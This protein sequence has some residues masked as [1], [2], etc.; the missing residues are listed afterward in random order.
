MDILINT[1]LLIAFFAGMASL[2]AP[3]CISVLL[4]TYFASIF[5][6]K[7]QVFFMTFVYF[8][9]I[10]LVFL[11]LGLGFGSL[12]VLFTQFH[13]WIYMGGA[14]FLLILAFSIF[15]GFHFML[16]LH[17][18]PKLKNQNIPSIFILGL[19]SGLATTCCAP[20]LAGVLT[21]SVL[22]GS[23]LLG[24]IYALTY[25]LGMVIPL[26]I[27]AL[28]LDKINFTQKFLIF[29][30]TLSYKILGRKVILTMSNF[31][32]SLMF[33]FMGSL[34]L[35]LGVTGRLTMKSDFQRVINVFTAK[36]LILITDFIKNIPGF[37]FPLIFILIFAV[38]I[39]ITLKQVKQ[40]Q[41]SPS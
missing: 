35:F 8:I 3:C 23:I 15:L 41:N 6:Q 2:F 9:G 19:F 17:V 39:K 13:D 31:F 24:S 20:V 14:I 7:K 10:L 30:K 16:P 21:L 27:I 5:R 22:P 1:S 32:A 29:R 11:P 33:L 28:F 40:N 36:Y 25:V 26:F 34:I 4:P 18:S 38:I 12:G 37:V